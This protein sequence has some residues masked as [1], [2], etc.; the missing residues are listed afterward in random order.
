MALFS[1]VVLLVSLL[2]LTAAGSVFLVNETRLSER[3]VSQLQAAGAAEVAIA[4]ALDSWDPR[5]AMPI[6]RGLY[7]IDRSGLGLLVRLK[8]VAFPE[9]A[10]VAGG[11]VSLGPGARVDGAIDSGA[12]GTGLTGDLDLSRVASMADLTMPGGRYGTL[13]AAPGDGVIHIEG[14]VE[15]WGGSGSGVLLVDG[16][17]TI[18]GPLTFSG[19]VFVWGKLVVM[20]SAS[21]STHLSGSVVTSMGTTGDSSLWVTYSKALVDKALSKF[22]TPEK[23]RGRSWTSLSQ[24][25]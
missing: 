20:G 9:A 7:L 23:V 17:L 15:L 13:P 2:A 16:D 12:T 3:S 1:S 14:D 4:H 21:S 24:V 11:A 19:V 5:N 22:G 8:P 18:T 6:G 10:L 25:G